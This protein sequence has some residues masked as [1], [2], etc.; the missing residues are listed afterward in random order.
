MR[1]LRFQAS[2]RSVLPVALSVYERRRIIVLGAVTIL[3]LTALRITGFGGGDANTTSATATTTTPSSTIVTDD[4][5]PDPVILGGPAPLAPS[6]SA[7]IAYPATTGNELSGL[8]TFSNLGY[9]Q[10]PVCYST[11]VPAGAIVTVTNVNNGR[12]VKCTSV[13]SLLVPPGMTIMLHNS[14]FTD[15]AN[16]NDAPLPVKITW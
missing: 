10:T 9:T 12:T 4:S 3:A 7:A 5:V 6:G 2:L 15:I 13:Y 11:Q 14:V 8:A 1:A 16:L